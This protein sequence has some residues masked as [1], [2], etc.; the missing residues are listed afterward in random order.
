MIWQKIIRNQVAEVQEL[1]LED[2]VNRRKVSHTL[3][4]LLE[5]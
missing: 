2:L 4:E 1:A 3:S 5:K